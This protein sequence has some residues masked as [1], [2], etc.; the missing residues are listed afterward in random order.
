MNA[1]DIINLLDLKPLP[2]EG[3]YFRRVYESAEIIQSESLF[4][5]HRADKTMGTTIYALFTPA[6][7]SAMHRLDSDEI[8]H[9]Y[10][11]DP[12]E[13]LLL[14]PDGSGEVF[15]L[16][17]DFGTG[18]RP[19]KVV[20]RNVWQGSRV[21]PNGA[22]GFTLV[23]TTTVPGFH[24][25]GFELGQPAALAAEYPKFAEMIMARGR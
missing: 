8:Y 20:P 4:G 14:N 16:G 13:M 12:L 23:G 7:F 24:W 1:H 5:P 15:T 22:H 21:V 17:Q 19:Q 2:R 9:F 10:G 3:G 25:D 18:M 11:G 6:E